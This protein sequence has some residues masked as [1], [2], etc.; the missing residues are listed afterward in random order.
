MESEVQSQQTCKSPVID[1]AYEFVLCEIPP[2][3]H[4]VIRSKEMIGVVE[5]M[6]ADP[7]ECVAR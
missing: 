6:A 1:L 3:G 4:S 5:P 2:K 7:R